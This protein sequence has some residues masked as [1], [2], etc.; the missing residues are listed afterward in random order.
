MKNFKINKEESERIIVLH[1][2]LKKKFNF[3]NE[4]AQDAETKLQKYI[5]DGCLSLGEMTN[6]KDV[7]GNNIPA[8]KIVSKKIQGRVY[9]V[10]SDLSYG[11]YDATGKFIYEKNKLSCPSYTNREEIEK[12]K[13]TEKWMER[14]ETNASNLD[15]S[16]KDKWDTIMVGNVPL[17]K[18]KSDTTATESLGEQ[19]ISILD[20]LERYGLYTADKVEARYHV[21]P[22]KIST[23]V[24]NYLQY[25]REDIS[26]YDAPPKSGTSSQVKD[27]LESFKEYLNTLTIPDC[28]AKIKDFYDGFIFNKLSGVSKIEL[29]RRKK[30]VEHCATKYYFNNP[31]YKTKKQL[32]VLAGYP[33]DES[34]GPGPKSPYRITL[35]KK[36]KP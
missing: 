12:L 9:F 20:E 18:R 28:R 32:L 5:D 2:E 10:F 24:D 6:L 35:P 13:Q 26:L 1:S 15:L 8:V 21:N 34:D 16:N 4:Q 33:N 7:N 3:L 31:V 25:F 29:F 11:H 19:A 27:G 17:Y 23:L 22:I 30:E 36:Y 14:H